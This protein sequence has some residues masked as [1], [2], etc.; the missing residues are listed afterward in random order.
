MKKLALIFAVASVCTFTFTS[1]KQKAAEEQAQQ[2]LDNALNQ[3]EGEM[4]KAA[5][6]TTTVVDSAAATATQA[7]AGAVEAAATATKEATK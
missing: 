2:E 4:N 6:A 1:C 7:A 5:A 3:L